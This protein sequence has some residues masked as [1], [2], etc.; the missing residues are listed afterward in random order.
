M[1]RFLLVVFCLARSVLPANAAPVRCRGIRFLWQHVYHP[2]RLEVKKMCTGVTGTIVKKLGEDDGDLHIRLKLDSGFEDLLNDG[3][4]QNQGGNLVVEPI[5]DH[6]VTQEDAK[7][8][9]SDF[10]SRI[11]HFKNGTHVTVVGSYVLD[12][13]HGWMEIHPVVRITEIP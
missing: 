4:R 2:D 10:Q 12:H 5:C 1:S 8:A 13:E 11:P 6:T 7:A 3:N 9:C